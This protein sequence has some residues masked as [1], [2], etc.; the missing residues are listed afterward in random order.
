MATNGEAADDDDGD[1][2]E[3]HVENSPAAT[4]LPVATACP[5]VVAAFAVAIELAFS[6]ALV[7]I[8]EWPTTDPT[9]R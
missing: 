6:A 7:A 4:L 3:A 2:D 9:L 8:G 5:R 1:D